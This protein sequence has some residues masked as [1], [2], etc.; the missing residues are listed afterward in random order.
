MP[1][2]PWHSFKTITSNFTFPMH[3]DLGLTALNAWIISYGPLY[4]QCALTE[5]KKLTEQHNMDKD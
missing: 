1:K 2:L 5:L 4:L 3:P